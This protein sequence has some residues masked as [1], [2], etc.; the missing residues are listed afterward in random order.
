MI[1]VSYSGHVFRLN[2]N[3]LEIAG[4]I[5]LDPGGQITTSSFDL[6]GGTLMGE[7]TVVA[8]TFLNDGIVSSGLSPGKLDIHAPYVQGAEGRFL[9][10][11]GGLIVEDQHDVLVIEDVASLAGILEV[12][13]IGGFTPELGDHFDIMQAESFAGGFDTTI[14]PAH[15]DFALSLVNSDTTLRLTAI[16]VP[17]PATMGDTNGDGI[18]DELDLGNFVAQ[19]GG[20]PDLES[21]DFNGDNFVDLEDFALLRENFGFGVATAPDAE[22]EATTTPEPATLFLLA[23][24]GIA[25]L[26][27]RKCGMCV[28][29]TG[30]G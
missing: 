3:S 2:A 18:I 22:F 25:L 17:D 27:R 30:K 1:P 7:G 6:A 24:G 11:L 14:F 10:E 12:V 5:I 29:A 16:V 8:D 21:A 20:P 23:L 13:M 9:V 15:Y 26:G 4:T 28:T 19:F